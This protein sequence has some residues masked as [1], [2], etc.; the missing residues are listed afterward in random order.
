MLAEPIAVTLQV[1][2]ILEQL[3]IPYAIGG[4]L[5]SA[6][7]GVIRSTLDADIV[8]DLRFEHA[9]PLAIALKDN[10]YADLDMIEQAIQRRSSFNLLHLNT[11]FK[12]D[13]FVAKPN[14]FDQAQ[15]RRR[16]LQ[17]IGAEAEEQAYVLSPEDTILTKL[18]WYRLGGGV[19][20]RQWQDI[21][22][23]L[24]A[25][26]QRLDYTYMRQMAIQMGLDELLQ[27]ALGAV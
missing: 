24:K 9:K 12:V 1:V 8:A 15:L 2:K 5:A 27:K 18:D 25:Q 4:S 21:L 20:D 14:P 10:F 26:D 22:G 19:S 7:H 23:V 11:M 17:Q 16:Q 3:G 6:T 13:V